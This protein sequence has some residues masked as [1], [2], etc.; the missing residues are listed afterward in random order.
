MMN[1]YSV[2]EDCKITYVSEYCMDRI[3]DTMIYI[4]MY[5]NIVDRITDTMIYISMYLNIV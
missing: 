3:T 4:T 5:L 1:I 2:N